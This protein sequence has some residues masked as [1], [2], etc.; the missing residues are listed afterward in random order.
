VNF[1]SFGNGIIN[2]SRGIFGRYNC[3][4]LHLGIVFSHLMG[5]DG[6]CAGIE[7]DCEALDIGSR[8]EE[9]YLK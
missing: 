7:N 4:S 9:S 2:V 6:H 5:G 3:R 1:F 8:D